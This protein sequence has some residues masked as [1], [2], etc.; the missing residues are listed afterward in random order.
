[1]RRDA[2][3]L[4]FLLVTCLFLFGW[5]HLSVH[6]SHHENAKCPV[7]FHFA[8]GVEETDAHDISVDS[9]CPLVNNSCLSSDSAELYNLI[10]SETDRSRSPPDFI[11][12]L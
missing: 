2:R 8:N 11:T 7:C 4:A 12:V 6:D 1:M 9:I 10:E 3:K 5:L